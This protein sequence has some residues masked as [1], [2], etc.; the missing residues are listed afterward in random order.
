MDNSFQVLGTVKV[1]HRSRLL[2]LCFL[3]DSLSAL[4]SAQNFFMHEEV[5]SSLGHLSNEIN[6]QNHINLLAAE[7]F[8]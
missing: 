5:D 8:F 6:P 1:L 4:S 7:L 3:M 2:I